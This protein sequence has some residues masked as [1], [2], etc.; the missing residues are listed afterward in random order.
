MLNQLDTADVPPTA[1]VG[2]LHDVVRAD[3][4]RPPWPVEAILANAPQREDA[5][6]RVPAVLDEAQIE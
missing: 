4:P 3:E 2:G 5:Y 1:Q 6:F